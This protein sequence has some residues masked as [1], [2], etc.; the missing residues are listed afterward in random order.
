VE[1][2]KSGETSEL[3]AL[4]AK[5]SPFIKEVR[6]RIIFTVSVF[7]VS[8]ITGF[9]FYQKIIKFLINIL[10]LNG[11]N[12]VFTSP[13]QYINL[14]IS[15]GVAIGLVLVSPLLAYQILSF[16]K[17]A[18][19]EREYKMVVGFLPISAVLFLIGF[20]FGALVMKWQ[21]EV[22][23]I[24]STSLG[25]G[26]VLDISKLLSTVV[27]TSALMGIGFQ[28]PIILLLLLRI[29]II[30]H[31]QLSKQRLWVYLGSVIFAIL[32]PLD[33]ILAD[34]LLAMPLIVLFELT[35][36]LDSIFE[37]SRTKQASQSII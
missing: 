14:A 12:L 21:I 33:S 32:L 23:L 27:L 25:I 37:G 13:F 20:S 1:N 5:Y 31:N 29:G 4:V 9:V 34:V 11:I 10:N 30:K 8:T 15:C 22:F 28:F 7:A 36:I 16:L 19:R 6:K 24:S 18:L 35:L 26:N 17:P 3:S 2:T